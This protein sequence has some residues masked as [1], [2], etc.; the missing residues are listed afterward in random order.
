MDLGV[1]II[2]LIFGLIFGMISSI[3]G[4][5]GGALYMSLMVLLFTIPID[6]AR[7]TSTFIIVLFSGAAF[8][9]YF[10]QGKVDLKL[11]LIFAFLALLGGITATI[12]FLLFPIDNYILKII[13]AS[14]VFASGL[15]M[16]RKAIKSYNLDKKNNDVLEIEFSFENYDY[17]LKLIKGIP[18]F[19]FAGFV[20]YVSGIGGGMLF[21]PI[22]SIIFNIPIHYTTAISASM[23]FFIGI[24]NAGVRMI[25]GEIHYLI[26]ILIGIGAI[27][28]SLLGARTSS[29]IPKDYLQF[30]VAV[31]LIILS[32]R[33][34][35][36]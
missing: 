7:D 15:N 25:I 1:I 6:E 29:K 36:V 24:Y 26:G 33:L 19:F 28:G 30:G 3:T 8:I 17:K 22:L 10:R 34:Y 21:V 14:V 20:A 18:L 23:I 13:I 9:S 12:F 27:T 4:I 16:I 31:I 11:S 32:I 35:F 2:L 5:G